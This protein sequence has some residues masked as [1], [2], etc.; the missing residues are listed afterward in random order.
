MRVTRLIVPIAVA[1]VVLA[2]CANAKDAGG[3]ATATPTAVA[4]NGI[5]DLS[6]AEIVA[7]AAQATD[8]AG[9]YRVKGEI[10]QEGQRLNAD[11]QIKSK[12]ISGD[13]HDEPGQGQGAADRDGPLPPGRPG[14]VEDLRGS[15]GGDPRHP[16]QGQVGED[17]HVQQGVVRVRDHR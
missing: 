6:A 10:T 14:A 5:K 7:K 1:G 15:G 16:V 12:D 9:S 3:S 8:A 2:G 11:V 17:L 13:D 4:D